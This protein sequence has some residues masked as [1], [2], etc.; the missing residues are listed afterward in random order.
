MHGVCGPAVTLSL[1][2]P[3]AQQQGDN[4]PTTAKSHHSPCFGSQEGVALNVP[5]VGAAHADVS[6]NEWLSRSFS[7]CFQSSKIGSRF[8]F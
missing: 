7:S 5:L 4:G 2:V 6:G 8:N 1:V 3:K